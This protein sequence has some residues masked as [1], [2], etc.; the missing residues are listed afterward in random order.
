MSRIS[1]KIAHLKL[2]ERLF[3]MPCIQVNIIQGY[4]LRHQQLQLLHLHLVSEVLR[5][6]HLMLQQLIKIWCASTDVHRGHGAIEFITR[7][8]RRRV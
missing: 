4:V 5:S 2:N 3:K 7:P 8:D 1:Y 6:G